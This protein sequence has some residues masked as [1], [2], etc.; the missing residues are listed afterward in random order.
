MPT[1]SSVQASDGALLVG[2]FPAQMGRTHDSP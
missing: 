1:P 2:N